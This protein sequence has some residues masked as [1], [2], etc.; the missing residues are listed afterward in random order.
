[1]KKDDIVF[2]QDD[3]VFTGPS[4]AKQLWQVLRRSLPK[5]RQRKRAIAPL[6]NLE[7]EDKWIPHLCQLETGTTCTPAQLLQQCQQKIPQPDLPAIIA[8]QD[9]PSLQRLEAAFRATTPGKSTGLDPLPAALFHS[10]APALAKRFFSLLLKTYLWGEEPVQYKGGLMTMLHKKGSMSDVTNYRGIMLLATVSK[11]FHALL[12]QDLEQLMS[13]TRPQ[14][15]LGGFSGR[16]TAFGAQAL[17]TYG[18]IARGANKS[19]AVLFIDLQN[20]FH[21]LPRE[22]AIGKLYEADWQAVL[23]AL[24]DAGNPMEAYTAGQQLVSILER[25]QAPQAPLLLLRALRS[26]HAN[27]WFT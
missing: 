27:T 7:L 12:R 4:Q 22:L 14:C 17:R 8:V 18:N 5:M 6:K 19:C 3:I 9:I 11:R 1:M 24:A 21:R 15:Q 26:A 13:H 2:Y 10:Q 23:Q 20:A 25:L 16:Q